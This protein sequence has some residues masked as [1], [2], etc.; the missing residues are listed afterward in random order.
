MTIM[1]IILK[2]YNKM[3]EIDRK[4]TRTILRNNRYIGIIMVYL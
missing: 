1:T 2:Y 3:Y 4:Q